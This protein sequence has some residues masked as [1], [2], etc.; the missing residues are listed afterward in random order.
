[1]TRRERSH[2][3]ATAAALLLALVVTGCSAD[4]DPPDSSPTPRTTAAPTS[5]APTP[6]LRVDRA[7]GQVA[8]RLPPKVGRRVTG[9]V[10]EVVSTWVDAAFV[11]GSYP[12]RDFGKAFPRFTQSATRQARRDVKLMSNRDIGTDVDTVT[13][14]KLTVHVDVLA[15]RGQPAGVTARFA[16]RFNTTGDKEKKVA[17][18]GRLF[19]T[20]GAKG[21]W[22]VFGYD[23]TKGSK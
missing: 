16:L 18:R 4:E 15:A 1:M 14:R 13:G 17:V 7:L 5:A 9:D 21:G 8:G 20:R 6:S 23:V 12:R 3:T 19:L 22:R 2:T 11:G 10:A